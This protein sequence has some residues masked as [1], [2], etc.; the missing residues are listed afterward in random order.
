MRIAYIGPYQGEAL[1]K[2]RP[3]IF[4]FTLGGKVKIEL[5]AE[6][7]S[8][9]SHEV[10]ILSQGDVDRFK[11]RFY[12]AFR[13]TIPSN[14]KI[15]VFYASALPVKYLNG[16]WS[17]FFMLRLFKAR[18]KANPF[19]LVIIYNLKRG[20]MSCARFAKAHLKLPVILEYEDD[21]F[22][23][24]GVKVKKWLSAYHH[25]SHSRVLNEVSG[26]MAGSTRLL[27]QLP[28]NIPK[29]LL[30]GVLGE[31]IVHPRNRETSSR[32]NWVVFSG[33]H[34][35]PQGLEQL[36]QGWHL[37]KLTGW[38]L[39]IAG[40]G[41]LT[42]TLHQLAGNNSTIVFHGLLNREENA[43]LLAA[44]K[45]G[46]VPY[47]VSSTSGFSFKTIEYLAACLH[48]ITTPLAALEALEQ[49]LMHG[50]T[51]VSDNRPETIAASLKQV[52]AEHLYEHT[53]AEETV[54][55]YGPDAI[56]QAL[57]SLINRVTSSGG[58]SNGCANI[59]QLST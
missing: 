41:E 40:H 5:I 22:L 11:L 7:L 51:F 54:R 53:V 4:N 12:S 17:S 19:D 37:A 27:A 46:V 36:I 21:A 48:V 9:E 20:H 34:S 39:H 35:R 49:E 42:G 33:T 30:C 56:S 24:G 1:V 13:E 2:R 10:E 55:I 29:L 18:H 52:I 47:D 3:S 23:D 16:F 58:R 14:L 38:E 44:S 25:K 26:C 28:D 57:A 43:G 15:P 45:I 31:A 32:K 8:K 59:S 50:I 6:L